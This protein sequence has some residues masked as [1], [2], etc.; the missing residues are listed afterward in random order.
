M[1][2][3]VVKV[4]VKD[5][6]NYRQVQCIGSSGIVNLQTSFVFSS[7]SYVYEDLWLKKCQSDTNYINH[8]KSRSKLKLLHQTI[9]PSSM[10]RLIS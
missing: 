6:C 7:T 9:F 10:T 4:C 5:A 3:N 2:D 1:F 8:K